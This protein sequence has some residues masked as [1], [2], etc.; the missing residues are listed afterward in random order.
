MLADQSRGML[1][2]AA[3]GVHRAER[4]PGPGHG[5]HGRQSSDRIF[6]HVFQNL[7]AAGARADPADPP[8]SLRAARRA[9]PPGAGRGPGQEHLRGDHLRRDRR[10]QGPKVYRILFVDEKNDW[11]SQM[12]A[13]FASK[14]FPESGTLRQRRLGSRRSTSTP[15][16]WPSWTRGARSATARCPR[17]IQT[18]ARD[19]LADY[20][21][22]VSLGHPGP[23]STGPSISHRP[24]GVGPG[25][26]ES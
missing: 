9:Q 12:A 14:A 1:A 19:A 22:I 23:A 26:R 11:R 10:D 20:H 8:G 3:Q 7:I 17:Q 16:S 13:A 15:E 2:Q 24:A 18:D 5:G 6:E 25:L 21:V 4:R